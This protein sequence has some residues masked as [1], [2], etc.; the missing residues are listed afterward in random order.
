M[1]EE[2]RAGRVVAACSR[3]IS[4]I[5]KQPQPEVRVGP[6]GI[7]GDYHSGPVDKHRRR[8][9][10]GPNYRQIT[11]VARE[12]V[13]AVSRELGLRLQPG[14]LGENFLV[15][16]HGDLGDLLPGDQLRIGE[17]VVLEVT[18]RNKPCA[19]L[20]IYGPGI[21]RAFK[22]RRGILAVV[23]QTGIARPGDRTEIVR[24]PRSDGSQV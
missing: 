9:K 5:P 20:R 17:S 1:S 11:V 14:D 3:P 23:K 22:R 7:V 8:G 15:E 16:G 10:P 12:A 6:L 4:G 2:S 24:V 21:E 18:G 13:D 19:T